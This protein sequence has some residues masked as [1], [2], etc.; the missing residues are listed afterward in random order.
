MIACQLVRRSASL[1]AS[2]CEERVSLISATFYKLL[3]AA[4]TTPIYYPSRIESICHDGNQLDEIGFAVLR[5]MGSL[6]RG[7]HRQYDVT[8]FFQVPSAL[9]R[10]ELR[11]LLGLS[12]RNTDER[13]QH[14]GTVVRKGRPF[15][16]SQNHSKKIITVKYV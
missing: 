4:R 2:S 7:K 8:L 5:A 11:G 9:V 14:E 6:S 13:R 12:W 3:R 15:S 10:K 1:F 16:R